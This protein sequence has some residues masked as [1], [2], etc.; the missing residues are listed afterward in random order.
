MGWKLCL[1]HGT[2]AWLGYVMLFMN[3]VGSLVYIYL[4]KSKKFSDLPEFLRLSQKVRGTFNL[5]YFLGGFTLLTI[6]IVLGA[7]RAQVV[8]SNTFHVE[9]K[10]VFTILLWIYYFVSFL[11]FIAMKISKNERSLFLFSLLCSIGSVLIIINIIIGNWL[12]TGL[13]DFL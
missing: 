4:I 9:T 5:S 7:L 8:W 10:T 12:F 13:H 6:A 1:T 3:G 11:I 2:I